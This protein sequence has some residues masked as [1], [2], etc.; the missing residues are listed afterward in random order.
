MRLKS[1][2]GNGNSLHWGI[3]G[4]LGFAETASAYYGK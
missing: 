3:L 4:G 1:L 2:L